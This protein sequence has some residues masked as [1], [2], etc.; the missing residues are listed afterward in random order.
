MYSG[1]R[2]TPI[3]LFERSEKEVADR[4]RRKVKALRGVED[5]KKVSLT[6]TRKKPRI[7]LLVTLEGNPS[8]EE[9]HVICS[10]IDRQVRHTMPNARLA[11]GSETSSFKDDDEAVRKI[12]K[13]IAEEEPGSRGAQNIHLRGLNGKVGVD[14]LLL[15]ADIQSARKVLSRSEIEVGQKLKA[16]DSRV[17]E[18]VIHRE[19]ISEFVLGERSGHGTEAR[20]YIEHVA[21]HFPSLSMLEPPVI[22]A[23][24]DQLRVRIRVAPAARISPESANEV[25]SKF[26]AAI[27]NGFQA[28]TK[29]DIIQGTG[30][31]ALGVM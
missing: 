10:T 1:C 28:I 29:V 7:Q 16:A 24:G 21:K 22:R 5:C 18:V 23:I 30:D 3:P 6:F 19:S 14:F 31:R 25:A 27:K 4:I 20:C 8:Y 15:E 26:G 9:T 17:S 12:V 13:R 11:I 2:S